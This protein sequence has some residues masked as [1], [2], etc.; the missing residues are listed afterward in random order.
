MSSEPEVGEFSLTVDTKFRFKN[1]EPLETKS[2]PLSSLFAGVTQRALE[3]LGIKSVVLVAG[4]SGIGKTELFLSNLGIGASPIEAGGI[5][6][7]LSRKGVTWWYENLQERDEYFQCAAFGRPV[8]SED[9]G[10]IG[11]IEGAQ[12]LLL[13]EGGMMTVNYELPAAVAQ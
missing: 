7:V 4:P 2:G 1:G 6:T 5:A 13:D 10:I 8:D 9:E 11:N 3:V 12:I